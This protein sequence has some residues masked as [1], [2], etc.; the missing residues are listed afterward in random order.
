MIF[1]SFFF[2]L[3][4]HLIFKPCSRL[5]GSDRCE[6]DSTGDEK[7]CLGGRE[8]TLFSSPGALFPSSHLSP[9]LGQGQSL[10][11]SSPALLERLWEAGAVPHLSQHGFVPVWLPAPVS[12]LV[13]TTQNLQIC[14]GCWIWNCC[15]GCRERGACGEKH[16]KWF[17]WVVFLKKASL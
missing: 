4:L 9:L 13:T 8:S 6:T 17:L 14:K 1:F 5:S 3:L 2:P 12:S 7:L 16:L 10:V 15:G 11:F